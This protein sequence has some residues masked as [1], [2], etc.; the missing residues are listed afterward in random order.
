MALKQ[1]FLPA[2]WFPLVNYHSMNAHLLHVRSS[3]ICG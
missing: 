3:I 1:V 2:L